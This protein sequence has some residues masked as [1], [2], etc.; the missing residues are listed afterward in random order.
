MIRQKFL[1][2]LELRS[3]NFLSVFEIVFKT[4]SPDFLYNLLSVS[5]PHEQC[6]A[7]AV[8]ACSL[9]R[10]KGLRGRE[11][12]PVC[13]TPAVVVAVGGGVGVPESG[14]CCRR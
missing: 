14:S 1:A 3:N 2:V 8:P 6:G 11:A 4:C 5:S 7:L 13:A 9:G 10:Q 12:L